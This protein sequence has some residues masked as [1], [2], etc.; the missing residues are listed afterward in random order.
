MTWT[1]TSGKNARRMVTSADGLAASPSSMCLGVTRRSVLAGMGLALL[2]VFVGCSRVPLETTTLKEN[3]SNPRPPSASLPGS[4]MWLGA[5]LDWK[6]DSLPQY[7]ARLGHAPAVAVF[8]TMF[9]SRTALWPI[10][11]P[12]KRSAPAACCC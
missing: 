11:L 5:S 6:Q 12:S 7:T 9:H 4:G 8:S 2:P 3:C 1:L 10:V